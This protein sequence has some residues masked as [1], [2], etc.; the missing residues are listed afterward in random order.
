MYGLCM[1]NHRSHQEQNP[2]PR[3]KPS[4]RHDLVVKH[5][6]KDDTLKTGFNLT[7]NCGCVYWKTSSFALRVSSAAAMLSSDRCRSDNVP[8][9]A[10]TGR[11]FA[12]TVTTRSDAPC[13]ATR[14]KKRRYC[15][16]IRMR[17]AEKLPERIWFFFLRAL[18]F[19]SSRR[20]THVFF[21][22]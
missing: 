15:Y 19:S 2:F 10:F 20:S 12:T 4:Y 7:F 17:R 3:N 9:T 5:T 16:T 18:S 8:I 13:L 1:V 11:C 21:S 22:V 14:R 6:T